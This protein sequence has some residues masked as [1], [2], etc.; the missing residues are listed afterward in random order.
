MSTVK[1]LRQ[2]WQLIYSGVQNEPISFFPIILLIWSETPSLTQETY[3]LQ[4][5][6]SPLIWNSLLPGRRVNRALFLSPRG[7]PY[8][9][10]QNGCR[11]QVRIPTAF[12]EDLSLWDLSLGSGGSHPTCLCVGTG[13]GECSPRVTCLACWALVPTLCA[14]QPRFLLRCAG[15]AGLCCAGAWISCWNPLP[16][17]WCRSY[18][19]PP[20]PVIASHGPVTFVPRGGGVLL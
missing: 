1:Y 18:F 2:T 5:S 11:E 7:V 4:I 20:V 16:V 8:S 3:P 13:V 12:W 14:L 9:D 15:V 19:H 10:S 6:L 17:Q